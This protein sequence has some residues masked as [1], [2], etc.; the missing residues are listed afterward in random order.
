MAAPRSSSSTSAPRATAS[1]RRWRWRLRVVLLA[2]DGDERVGEWLI[3]GCSVLPRAAAPARGRG[4][5]A[6]GARRPGG[7][8][9]GVRGRGLALRARRRAATLVLF[10]FLAELLRERQVLAAMSH[11]L[12]NREIGGALGIS[13]HTAKFHVAQIIAKLQAQSRA[14]RRGQ[15]AA[16]AGSRRRSRRAS[17]PSRP[18]RRRLART[19]RRRRECRPGASA[20]QRVSRDHTADCRADER[21]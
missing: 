18:R 6:G 3:D 5:R 16:R 14:H 19:A 1:P 9:A 15:Q 11:G 12:G 8:D 13:A 10:G 21:T 17:I 20:S 7:D 4:R 2:A